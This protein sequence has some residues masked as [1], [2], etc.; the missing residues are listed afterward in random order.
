MAAGA[1]LVIADIPPPAKVFKGSALG[2]Q[3]IHK[4]TP[5]SPWVR[6]NEASFLLSQVSGPA[7]SA[8]SAPISMLTLGNRAVAY[9]THRSNKQSPTT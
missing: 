3:A 6:E 8:A 9:H 5:R 1:A 7:F 2:I 4:R